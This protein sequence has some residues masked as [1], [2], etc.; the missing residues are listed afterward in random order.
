M[1]YII[2]EKN[3]TIASGAIF[4]LIC[5]NTPKKYD[6]IASFKDINFCYL[7]KGQSFVPR[8]SFF[9]KEKDLRKTIAYKSAFKLMSLQNLDF[10]KLYEA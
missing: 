3:H 4:P 7:T 5:K 6:T 9:N 10:K 1:F 8:G 2:Y